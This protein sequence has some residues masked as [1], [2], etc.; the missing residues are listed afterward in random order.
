MK[1]IKTENTKTQNLTE[2]KQQHLN[3]RLPGCLK[4]PGRLHHCD[5]KISE[6][7]RLPSLKHHAT[8]NQLPPSKRTLTPHPPLLS[9]LNFLTFLSTPYHPHSSSSDRC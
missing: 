6:H 3:T 8:L 1:R 5:K 4:H 9:H 7:K 2:P